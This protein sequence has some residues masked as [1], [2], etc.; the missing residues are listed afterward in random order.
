MAELIRTFEM[1]LTVDIGVYRGRS[2]FP[3]ALSHRECSGG[4]STHGAP[5]MLS[6]ATTT[7]FRQ[8][9]IPGSRRQTLK[10]SIMMSARI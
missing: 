1:K 7:P 6:N 3:Q 2:L 10:D 8:S 5:L 9:L 4:I